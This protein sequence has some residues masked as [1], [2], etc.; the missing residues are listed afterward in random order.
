MHV[1]CSATKNALARVHRPRSAVSLRMETHTCTHTH[2]HKHK[3]KHTQQS[4]A[5]LSNA[6]I[7]VRTR[8][9]R[10]ALHD[11]PLA[12]TFSMRFRPMNVDEVFGR[13]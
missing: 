8:T 6:A 3:H 10:L 2:T 1:A 5:L 11:A 12:R 4:P 13:D 9:E 7:K